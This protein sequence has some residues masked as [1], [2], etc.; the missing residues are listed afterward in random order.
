M[1]FDVDVRLCPFVLRLYFVLP[2]SFRHCLLLLFHYLF[3]PDAHCLAA[4]MSAVK[5]S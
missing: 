1:A 3:S 5:N 2:L 4:T